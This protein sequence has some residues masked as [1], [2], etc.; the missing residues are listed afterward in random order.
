MKVRLAVLAAAAAGLLSTAAPAA[1]QCAGAQPACPY[2]ALSQTGQRDGGVL[3]FPQ[4][5]AV[6]PDGTV[7]VGDQGSR[8]VQAFAPDGRFL[9]SIGHAGTRPGELAGVGALAVAGDGSLV[10]AD[11]Q[12][13]IHRFA[14]DG[15]HLRTWGRSG[16]GVGE[17]RFG[18]GRGNDAGAGGGLAVSRGFVY[19]AD[20]GN[21]RIQRFD[22]DGGRG[23]V[24]VPE[25]R[26]GY[27][28][29]L[30]IRGSRLFVADNQNHRVLVMDTGGR[31]LQEIRTGAG[32][33]G[34]PM[35]NPYGVAL[36][37]AGRLY[38]S[39]NMGQRVLRFSTASTKYAYKARWGQYGTA[40]GR[41]AYPRAIATDADGNVL[42]ANT[43]NDRVD[44]FDRG[45]RLLRSFGTSGRAGGQFGTP[46]GVAADAHGMRAVTDSVNG[47]V[48]ILSPVGS[49]LSSWGS[50]APGPT[51]LPRP[52]AV[53]FDAE[54]NAFVLDQRRARIVA[55]SRATGQPAGT[56]AA[57]GRGP[58]RLMDPTALAIDAAGVLYVA[59]A[60]NDRIARFRRDGTYLGAITGTGAGR[61][62]AVTPDGSRIY[63]SDTK[64]RI[65]VYG[66]D[67]KELLWF[68]G[69]GN[70]LGKLEAPAQMTLDAAGLLW[71]AD[72]GNHRV[73]RFGPNGERLLTFGTR[74]TGPGQFLQ[75]TGVSV[76]C[77]GLLTVT[78]AGNNRVQSF[79][80]TTPQGVPP[81]AEL[82]A[83]AVPPPPKLPTLPPPD[84]PQ[85]SVKVLRRGAVLTKG[86]P[87][88][89]G[90]DTPCT[91]TLSVRVTPRARPPRGRRPVSVALRGA[92]VTIPAGETR[93]LRARA[94]KAQSRAVRRAL[95]GK[96]GLRATLQLEARTQETGEA[97]SAAEQVDVTR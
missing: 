41:L 25:G 27:P 32:R 68:G 65:T 30:A 64:H 81:C 48:Q 39:D 44:V 61:G 57:Q 73:Q 76:D 74:G 15:R 97:S 85:L 38:V 52:V 43:G 91:V 89:V 75:P 16:T 12:N 24:I 69:R 35:Q 94:T 28:K 9:R 42:V 96:K 34:S 37:K 55:F 62:I 49:L 92:K 67:G 6:A 58:G 84:G 1:A 80:L 29:G 86:L 70:K 31:L 11:G 45:G 21:G 54:G 17:F 53:V 59:D 93:I 10:V 13:R 33:G 56:I 23:S 8:T 50:P 71:V 2:A 95:R 60:G 82:A 36:D 20:S 40:P 79:A 72:R 63:L 14:A 87:V 46:M 26:L 77:R 66:P 7:Y 83:P 78:D 51:I 22:L 5:I 90:C 3:R 19:V 18:G 47:R 88:R 4:A